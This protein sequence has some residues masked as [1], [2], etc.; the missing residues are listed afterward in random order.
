MTERETVSRI[1][2]AEDKLKVQHNAMSYAARSIEAAA[3]GDFQSAVKWS[4][5]VV[6]LL[7]GKK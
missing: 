3:R 2:A 5:Q 7:G 6:R 1:E 4:E